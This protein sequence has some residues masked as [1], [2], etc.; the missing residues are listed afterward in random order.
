MARLRLVAFV[1]ALALV[2]SALLPLAHGASGHASD[3]GVCSSISHGGVVAD[4]P[5]AP[6]LPVVATRP[7]HDAP[8]PARS[9]PW[10]GFD[11][12]SARAPPAD[13]VPV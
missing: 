1:A 4:S 9:S 3:C 11:V 10:R 2:S 13:S 6:D 7:A 5:P 8:E 12:R